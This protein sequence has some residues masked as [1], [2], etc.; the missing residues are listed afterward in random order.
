MQAAEKHHS[1]KSV[2]AAA[3]AASDVGAVAGADEGVGAS[4][5]R[6]GTPDRPGELLVNVAV[7]VCCFGIAGADLGVGVSRSVRALQIG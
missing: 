2:F 3:A 4:R 5:K 1:S 7:C 6:K